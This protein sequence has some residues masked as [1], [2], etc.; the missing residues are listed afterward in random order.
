MGAKQQ[1]Q[2]APHRQ[3]CAARRKHRDHTQADWTGGLIVSLAPRVGRTSC[4]TPFLLYH[5]PSRQPDCHFDDTPCLSTLKHLLKVQGGAKPQ[6]ATATKTR[7]ETRMLPSNGILANGC[8][9]R[10]RASCSPH[11]P[12]ARSR[13][14]SPRVGC[15]PATP[16]WCGG[17]R[18]RFEGGGSGLKAVSRSRATIWRWCRGQS[19]ACHKDGAAASQRRR[20]ESSA[21]AKES[22]LK[23]V[24]RRSNA[25]V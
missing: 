24:P 12:G 5:L 16:R 1:V 4:T 15:R 2:R 10:R 8:T 21:A 22:G 13:P 25:A 20:F 11:A 14:T 17:Q 6:P 19:K 7:P 18:R 23:A 3:L 9:C